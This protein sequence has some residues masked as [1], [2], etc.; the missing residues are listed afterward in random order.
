MKK[1]IRRLII[2][3]IVLAALWA[4]GTF[5]ITTNETELSD[6]RIDGDVRIAVISDLHGS[7]FGGGNRRLIKRI[8]EV[9]PDLVAAVGDMYTYGDRRGE[10]AAQSLLTELAREFDVY[11][12]SGEHD[13]GDRFLENIGEAGVRVLN[14]RE[15]YVEYNGTTLH[16]YGIDNAYYSNT[17]D[18]ANEFEP[19]EDNFTVLLAH[20]PNFEPF[21]R[22]G[23]DLSICGDT[24]GGQVR[25]PF[26]G[27]VYNEGIWLPELSGGDYNTSLTKGM[28]EYNDA[29]LFVTSGLGNYPVP[30]RLFNRPEVAVITLKA[31]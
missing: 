2:L 12:V 20:I 13:G 29:H 24:H 26:I 8:R 6:G 31:K 25:L 30:V 4:F 17:F 10:A 22:F 9:S 28:Y 19:D 27:A 18:L 5:T 23:I 16:L 11:Y 7:S 21:A 3:F 14:Y 1:G 15:E